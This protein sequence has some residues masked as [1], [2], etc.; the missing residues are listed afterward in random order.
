MF[1]G[2]TILFAG[3][4][5]RISGKING[6]P[7]GTVVRLMTRNA[8]GESQNVN[9]G[10]AQGG[11]FVFDVP[12][13]ELSQYF[14]GTGEDGSYA[15]TVWLEPG[16]NADILG[17]G[18][19][20]YNWSVESPVERQRQYNTFA[21]LGKE[22]MPKIDSLKKAY[23]TLMDQ[24][25][26]IENSEMV[27]LFRLQTRAVT[28]DLDAAEKAWAGAVLELIKKTP[29]NDEVMVNLEYIAGKIGGKET[30]YV[31]YKDDVTALYESL[32]DSY[33]NGD[34]GKKIYSYLFETGK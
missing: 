26:A 5:S 31:G 22:Y 8:A 3:Q 17:Q 27:D 16:K 25:G 13:S 24:Q 14:V 7:D 32:P 11:S 21:V 33:K 18:A 4:T 29:V 15:V 23:N 10:T 9:N 20:P 28:A 34:K 6:L 19:S 2:A 30:G 1:V 12:V